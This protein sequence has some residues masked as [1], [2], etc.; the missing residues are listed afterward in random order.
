MALISLPRR[1]ALLAI[2]GC[3]LVGQAAQAQAPAWPTKPIKFVVPFGPGGANDLVA[4]TVAEQ[5]GKQ[6]G[7]T[8]II[9]NKPGAG[10][11]LGPL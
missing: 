3:A 5:A 7:Q 1:T 9:E 11:M 2:A 8:I 6:L 4:R 10:S